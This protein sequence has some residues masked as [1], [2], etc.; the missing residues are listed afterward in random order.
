ML[1]VVL[2]KVVLLQHA[3]EPWRAT[4]T[5]KLLSDNRLRPHLEVTHWR[6]AGRAHN[7]HLARLIG[8]L[9]APTLLWPGGSGVLNGCADDAT[10]PRGYILIDATWQE[11]LT[12]FRRG[13][14]CL[15]A[16]PRVA[17][18][19]GPSSYRL[20]AEY[21]WGKRFGADASPAVEALCTAETAAGVLEQLAGDE[22]GAALLRTVFSEFQDEA[23]A[24]NAPKQ[25]R[26]QVRGPRHHSHTLEV[27]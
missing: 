5:G 21:G 11:A 4:G 15:K 23:A 8:L 19:A 7:E 12:I 24:N 1:C 17:L 9:D 10:T 6:W 16:L 22:A 3:N 13:P 14:A 2:T 20:R 27:L 25:R 26:P 18:R